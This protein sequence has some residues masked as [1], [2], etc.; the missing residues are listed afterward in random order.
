MATQLKIRRGTTA[1][2]ASFT[3]AEGEITLDTTKD[4]LVA[5]D[6]YTAGGRPMLREDLNNLGN[7]SVG[8]AKLAYGSAVAGTPIRVNNAGNGVEYSYRP[9]ELIETL[10]GHCRGQTLT[11][12]MGNVTWP[13]VT[14][15]LTLTTSYQDM[16]GS[17]VTYTPPPGTKFV[18]YQFQANYKDNESGGI[19]HVRY[20]L[21]GNEVT[22]LYQCNAFN[23]DP[24]T[25]GHGN[26]NQVMEAWYDLSGS[27]IDYPT[28]QLPYSNWASG[29]NMKITVREYSTGYEGSWHQNTWRDGTSAS[30][31]FA[32]RYP[33]LKI[34]AYA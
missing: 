13:N 14:G 34:Q 8:A 27:T 5:H 18:R 29:V 26:M 23:Y 2:H 16:T 11:G 25:N 15:I 12:M 4:T 6:N 9:G 24:G 1:E 17:S 21:N 28:G 7:N 30:G 10:A 33:L 3:G 22:K 20:Y 32:W 19:S 31:D